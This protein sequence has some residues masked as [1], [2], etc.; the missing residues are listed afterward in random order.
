MLFLLK[1][2]AAPD[3]PMAG[4]LGRGHGNNGSLAGNTFGRVAVCRAGS[5]FPLP[6]ELKLNDA[7]KPCDFRSERILGTASYTVKNNKLSSNDEFV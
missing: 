2:A 6:T 7:G 1:P 4:R 5:S 3:V